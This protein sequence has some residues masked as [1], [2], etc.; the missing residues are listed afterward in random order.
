LLE[1]TSRHR[2]RG[3]LENNLVLGERS[4]GLLELFLDAD[5]QDRLVCAGNGNGDAMLKAEVGQGLPVEKVVHRR[6]T[7]IRFGDVKAEKDPLEECKNPFA[8]FG[9][10]GHLLSVSVLGLGFHAIRADVCEPRI[11]VIHNSFELKP[12][13][14]FNRLPCDIFNLL[15]ANLHLLDNSAARGFNMD[16]VGICTTT[17]LG[18]LL[19][20]LRL[21]KNVKLGIGNKNHWI[22]LID[23]KT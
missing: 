6:S 14:K 23:L 11:P 20:F 4:L 3:S 9:G 5:A 16:K 17:R 7:G 2:I 21:G 19:V 10:G 12:N 15:V 8:A 18:V 22:E 1:L 13:R